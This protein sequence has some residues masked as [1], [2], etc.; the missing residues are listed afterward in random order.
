MK[1]PPQLIYSFSTVPR[2]GS[3]A[4]AAAK[5]A[6]S[7]ATLSRHMKLLEAEVG[8]DLFDRTTTGLQVTPAGSV[9]V[10][11]AHGLLDSANRFAFAAS[12]VRNDPE[13]AVRLTASEGLSF[14][15]LP[16]IVAQC[17]EA[18][19]QALLDIDVTDSVLD[20]LG[21]EADVALRMFRPME[22][23]LVTKLVGEHAVAP[24]AADSYLQRF[25]EP[26]TLDELLKH[27]LIGGLNSD[28]VLK[29]F[30]RLGYPITRSAFKIRCDNRALGWQMVREGAG[31]GFA[32]CDLGD[33]TPGLRRLLPEIPP[34]RQEIWLAMRASSPPNSFAHRVYDAIKKFF[35]S[36]ADLND[37]EPV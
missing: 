28:V 7:E 17:R 32:R 25:G 18:V 24:Y 21:S 29:S 10:E 12:C 36:A 9:L 27:D 5:L 2:L 1:Y 15:L 6:V 16:A 33:R 11:Y 30:R 8:F 4:K 34:F 37:A 22:D 35:A 19:P 3:L 31:I 20:L 14:T 13:Q 23:C 26:Y